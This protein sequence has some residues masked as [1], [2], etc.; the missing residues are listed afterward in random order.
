MQYSLADLHM[1]NIEVAA[2]RLQQFAL[3]IDDKSLV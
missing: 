1:M 3:A 2:A